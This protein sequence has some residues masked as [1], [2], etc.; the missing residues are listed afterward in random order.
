[1]TKLKRKE[2]RTTIKTGTSNEVQRRTQTHPKTSPSF[3]KVTRKSQVGRTEGV[4]TPMKRK[5][6]F[7]ELSPP[8]KKGKNN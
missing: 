4:I 1:M 8:A 7:R 5:S 3:P 2:T 6:N